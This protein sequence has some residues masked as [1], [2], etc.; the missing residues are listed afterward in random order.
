MFEPHLDEVRGFMSYMKIERHL[1]IRTAEEYSRDVERFGKFIEPRQL[2][3]AKTKH[4]RRFINGL[5][6]DGSNQPQSVHRKIAA[7]KAFYKWE[8]REHIRKRNPVDEIEKPKCGK[9]LAQTMTEAEVQ[10]L[11]LAAASHGSDAFYTA[12][13]RALMEA[14]YG[15]GLRRAEVVGLNV[16]SVDLENKLVR[17]VGKGDKERIV[18]MGERSVETIRAWL[19]IRPARGEALFVTKGGRRISPRQL[20][21]IFRSIVKASGIEKKVVPHTMRHSFATHLHDH[22]ADLRTIQELLGHASVA[23]TE[24]YAHVSIEHKRAQFEK[25]HPRALLAEE[26]KSA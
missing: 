18:F 2:R 20:W 14:L 19:E 4:V 1:S 7:L 11:L 8:V 5:M 23:T 21:V 13:D 12:R 22:G 17:V 10:S 25:A 3:K 24:R 26:A 6:E 15:S 9:R 16:S